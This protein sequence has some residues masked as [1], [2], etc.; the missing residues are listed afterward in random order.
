[1]DASSVSPSRDLRIL[2]HLLTGV[3]EGERS[4]VEDV[5]FDSVTQ[6]PTVHLLLKQIH[7]TLHERSQVGLLSLH[8]SPF[9]K[10]EE[11]FG[12][13]T[14]DEVLRT[15]A[16]QLLE[17]KRDC[18]RESDSV[19]E[20]SMSGSNFVFVL[21]PPRYN[22]FIYYADL[23]RL[24]QRIQSLLREKLAARF[25]PEVCSQFGAF[26]GCVVIN[27]DPGTPIERLIL[28]GLDA[29]YTDAFQERERELQERGAA[30]QRVIAER[31]IS[32]VYQPIVDLQEQRIAGYE[33]FTRGPPGDLASPEYLF[34][35]AYQ[36]KL[37]WQ[38]ERLCREEAVARISEL[39]S[40]VLLFLNV[41]PESLLDPELSRWSRSHGLDGRVVLEVTER[42]G[43]GDYILF[44]RMLELIRS[45]GL[46]LAIDDV[47]SAYSGLRMIAEVRPNF[48]KVDMGLT[49]G[50]EDD[51]VRQE[52]VGAIGAFAQRLG[53]PLIAEGVETR[54]ELDA[55]RAMGVRYVQGYLLARPGPGFAAVDFDLVGPR[56]ASSG[57][58]ESRKGTRRPKTAPRRTRG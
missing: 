6:L 48:I 24:R 21:S 42:A 15:I 7:S 17:I 29:A 8:V 34:K 3:A 26:V 33:A 20:I 56:Q 50:V 18:L 22:R 35:L 27:H 5:L 14:F 30:L 49:R 25:P 11:M 23:D 16:E 32:T 52:L 45:L 38:L 53:S 36:A 55:L 57:G 39:P 9:V 12:W 46:Q 47:G 1:M 2:E 13:K 43:V 58:S 28:R 40:G 44:R 31:L 4:A 54:E 51:L 10:L 19:A 37:L 41:D